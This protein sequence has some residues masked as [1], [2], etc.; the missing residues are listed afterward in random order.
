MET[1]GLLGIVV[2]KRLK[3]NYD[4]HA[5]DAKDSDGVVFSVFVIGKDSPSL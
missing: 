3:D 4:G 1:L 5:T 2:V